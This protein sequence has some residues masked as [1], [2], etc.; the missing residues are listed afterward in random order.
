MDSEWFSLSEEQKREY[1]H[2]LGVKNLVEEVR[3]H[4]KA[5]AVDALRYFDRVPEA[6]ACIED[7]MID[8]GASL[9][10]SALK[11]LLHWG[12][13]V[14]DI[15]TTDEERVAISVASVV[16]PDV[17]E[18]AGTESIRRIL[19]HFYK[20]G[21]S[22]ALDEFL[23]TLKVLVRDYALKLEDM[24]L[25]G[26]ITEIAINYPD[27]NICHRA[28]TLLGVIGGKEQS[29]QEIIDKSLSRVERSNRPMKKVARE[30]REQWA[31]AKE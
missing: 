28:I 9:H 29:L 5:W 17:W 25:V 19:A 1:A 27:Y 14:T 18:N 20:K 13:S 11:V 6:V 2:Q 21:W 4:K 31:K 3:R 23:F 16:L 22:Q 7:I 8:P 24:R 10:A 30:F 12:Y 15:A 26:L